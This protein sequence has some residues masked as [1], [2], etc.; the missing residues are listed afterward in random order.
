MHSTLHIVQ[1]AKQSHVFKVPHTKETDNSDWLPTFRQEQ[2]ECLLCIV[3]PYIQW[4]IWYN[5]FLSNLLNPLKHQ[6]HV[7][8]EKKK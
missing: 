3:Y 1:Y 8:N 2:Y 5:R 6:I 7:L 4:F